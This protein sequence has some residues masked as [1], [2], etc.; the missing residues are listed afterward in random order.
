MLAGNTRLHN[1]MMASSGLLTLQQPNYII[2]HLYSSCLL[3]PLG[4]STALRTSYSFNVSKMAT[5]TIKIAIISCPKG[6]DCDS[7]LATHKEHKGFI[8]GYVGR[9]VEHLEKVQMFVGTHSSFTFH[10]LST[11]V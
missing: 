5:P 3:I 10:C 8:C 9:Q 1:T 2:P 11:L 6:S 7:L 4:P